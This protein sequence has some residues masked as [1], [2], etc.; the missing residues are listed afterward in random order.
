MYTLIISMAGILVIHTLAYKPP[1]RIAIRSCNNIHRL[2][3]TDR[4]KLGG[5][6]KGRENFLVLH[7]RLL[8]FSGCYYTKSSRISQTFDAFNIKLGSFL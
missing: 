7:T 5:T 1:S 6:C 2:V 3:L 8:L 4:K